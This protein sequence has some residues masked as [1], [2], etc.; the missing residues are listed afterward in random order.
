LDEPPV[1]APL[2]NAARDAAACDI[3]KIKWKTAEPLYDM[4]IHETT[5]EPTKRLCRFPKNRGV[6][7]RKKGLIT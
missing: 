4:K 7:R 6:G 2:V 3:G 1:N 5:A